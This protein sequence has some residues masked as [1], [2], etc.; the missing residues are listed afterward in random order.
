MAIF[1]F[2]LGLFTGN[3]RNNNKGGMSDEYRAALREMRKQQSKLYRNVRTI[4]I[5][6]S[7]VMAALFVLALLV[8]DLRKPGVFKF[9]FIVLAFCAGGGMWLPWITQYERDRKKAANGENVAAWRKYIVYVFW[10]L[11]AVCSLLWAISVFIVG[12]GVALLI[13]QIKND[14]DEM[15]DLSKQFMMLRAAIVVTLQTAVGSIIVSGSMRYGKNYLLLRVITYAALLYLDFWLSWFV[16][17]V[18]FY[19][20]EHGFTPISNTML[21]VIAI[22]MIVAMATAGGIYSGQARRKEIELFMKGDT[23]ALLEGDVDLI[24]AESNTTTETSP[25]TPAA[26]PSS[27]SSAKDPEQQLVKIKELLDKGIITEE[28]YQAKRKDIIDKM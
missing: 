11:I 21:W 12:D 1:S 10:G 22:L 18:T 15:I 13:N 3:R 16:G 9:V 6:V 26:A 7:V 8:S 14:A 25:V 2:L 5:I 24:D 4:V 17:G 23:K 20:L 19:G 28:E 27:Q